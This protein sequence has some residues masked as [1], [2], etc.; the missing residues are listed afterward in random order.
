MNKKAYYFSI[1]ALIALLIILGV[2]LFIKPQYTQPE[3]ET[4][5][6]EDLIIALSS[7]KI[8]DLDNYDAKQLISSGKITNL[9]QSIL[10]QLGEF[11]A[12]EDPAANTLANSIFNGLDLGKN[13]GLYFGNNLIASKNTS[14]FS[15]AETVST[16][17]QVI[18]GV[19][20][21]NATKG[22]SA[23]AFLSS[24]NKVDYFYFGGYVGDGNISVKITGEILGANIEGV[25][26][27]PFNLSINGVN[28]G[29]YNPPANIPYKINLLDQLGKF[30]NGD[31]LIE[32]KSSSNL[33]IA[34][35]FVRVVF[36]SSFVPLSNGKKSFPGIE[37]LIN[38]YDSF[39]VPSTVYEMEV[40]LHYNSSYD[41]F[42]SIGNKT[43]Y[44]GNS[45]NQEKT[46][47]LNH[48]YLLSILDP[49]GGSLK[50]SNMHNKTIPV[51]IG[52]VN[53]S[54][55]YNI[56]LST[57]VF[58]VDDLS[59]SMQ[60]TSSDCSGVICG[61]G[62][63]CGSGCNLCDNNATKCGLCGGTFNPPTNKIGELKNA[64]KAFIDILLNST[65][66]RVGL[67]GYS[68]G[69]IN[70]AYHN[71]SRNN[72][73]L[74]A[75]VNT[76][77]ASGSTCICCGINS[78]VAD[79]LAN[80][81]SGRSRAL[82]LMSDG[83][84]NVRCNP[85]S[86]CFDS[87]CVEQAKKEAINAACNAYG[88]YSIK[89]YTIGFGNN[90]TGLNETTLQAIAQCS[91]G[92]YYYS[93]IGELEEKFHQVA[94]D[95]IKA[96]YV[97]QTISGTGIKTKL[98]PDSYINLSFDKTIPYGLVF[99]SETDI[100]NNSNSQGSFFIPN[101][102]IPY[103]ARVVSYSGSKWTSNV[104][105]YD[106]AS[107]S[108]NSFFNLSEY[109]VNFT[110]LGDPY[111]VDIPPSLITFGNNTIRVSIGVS[112]TNSTPGSVYD[113][114]IYSVVKEL[115]SYSPI[116]PS[117]RGCRWTIEFEDGSSSL[118]NVPGNYSGNNTCAYTSSS[119]SYHSNDAIDYAVFSVLSQMDLNKN[120]KIETKFSENDLAINSVEVAGIPFSW[121]T[122]VQVRVWK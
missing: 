65:D 22:Y 76:W 9:N 77:A 69:T 74:K 90:A 40:L 103:A 105:K 12:N 100:F 10:D 86:L 16:S 121:E 66:N 93:N 73:T 63:C 109:L 28:A 96:S 19:Q 33:Y 71:L 112:S 20:Q 58:S 108:W 23:R 61:S 45:S 94:Q 42:M 116:L 39:Y 84:A 24:A 114:V 68:T 3:Y 107:G 70:S 120:N 92:N 35:G 55:T 48:T 57:D 79:L 78:A 53:A 115:S 104:E 59:G 27:G 37:G 60:A 8:G 111:M 29:Y 87:A 98:Y 85:Y 101:D 88:N 17:R 62:R 67:M 18:S 47:V 36:G 106:D 64:T 83:E 25:F 119:I 81:T 2:V 32:F 51:R 41:I 54:Y 89:T 113:K 43:V 44:Q 117:A 52:F 95:V 14:L 49:D 13:I 110:Q 6:Q 26:S 38:V 72:V 4:H 99:V 46:V 75:E 5:L 11:Y 97:E 1:D 50:Y 21:G 15:D 7:V 34:G 82:V 56:T 122:E 118:V 30:N 31:N 102:T 80:S 91:G